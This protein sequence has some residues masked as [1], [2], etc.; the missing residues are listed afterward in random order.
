MQGVF[1]T[2]PEFPFLIRNGWPDIRFDAVVF[3]VR[4]EPVASQEVVTTWIPRLTAR[5]ANFF[6]FFTSMPW[7]PHSSKHVPLRGA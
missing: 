1:C 3:D 5:K 7:R 2:Y 4:I 6:Y